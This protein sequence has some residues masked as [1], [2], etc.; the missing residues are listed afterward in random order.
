MNN[1]QSMLL[2]RNFLGFLGMILP[3][4]CILGGLFVDNKT[5][6]WW[7]SISVTYYITPALSIVLGACSV[8]LMCY[9]SYEKIDT[10]IN[11]LSGIFGLLII[12]FPC[13]NP[14]GFN[15][16][17][18]FQIPVTVSNIIHLS[19]AVIFFLLLVFNIYFLF[20]KGH[21]RSRNNIYYSCSYIM[22]GSMILYVILKLLK[23]LPDWSVMLLESILLLC[24]GFAWLVKGRVIL[25]NLE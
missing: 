18:F 7:Y 8:F 6:G 2:H 22:L 21:S 17:G 1:K 15:Y 12:L 10:V 24:F 13:K 19:S 9:R 11:T 23:L 5:V 4:L 20:T 25:S 3:F 16:V 14:Y